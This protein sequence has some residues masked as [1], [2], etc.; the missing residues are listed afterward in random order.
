MNSTV[1]DV[2]MYI[3]GAIVVLALVAISTLLIFHAVPVESKDALNIA[4]G[5]LIAAALAVVQY[6]FGSSKGSS[7]KTALLTKPHSDTKE[8]P[9]GHPTGG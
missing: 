8:P 3:L 6:F 7:D 9:P 2:Y 5:A 1:K 4:L